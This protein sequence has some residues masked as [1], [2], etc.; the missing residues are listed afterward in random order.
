MMMRSSFCVFLILLQFFLGIWQKKQIFVYPTGFK[1]IKEIGR[2][3][4]Q[5]IWKAF[6]SE[7]TRK[8]LD[9]S[10]IF[11]IGRCLEYFLKRIPMW[12]IRSLHFQNLIFCY[13]NCSYLLWEKIVLVIK[14]NFWS[15]RL[16]AEN[17]QNF[18]NHYLEQFIQ[19]VKGQNNFWWPNVFLTC[20]LRFLISN[21]LEQSEFKLQK[22]IGI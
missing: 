14:K 19:T 3:K 8:W 2:K 13:Q 10:G 9:K 7:T 15:S 11:F 22:I 17:L 20:S 12:F 5:K 1:F 21:K 18:W 16:K 4:I 6:Q